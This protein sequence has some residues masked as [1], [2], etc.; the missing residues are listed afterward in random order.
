M[1]QKL[2]Y[3]TLK[4][5]LIYSI[6]ILLVFAP[7]FYFTIEELYIEESDEGLLLRKKEF[8][9]YHQ[10]ALKETE[11]AKWN[12]FNRD[13]K[14]TPFNNTIVADTLYFETIFDTIDNEYEP[15]RILQSPVTIESK[16]YTLKAR[17]NLVE[18]EDLI[19]TISFVFLV[20]MCLLLFGLFIITKLLSNKLWKPFFDSLHFIENFEIDKHSSFEFTPNAIDEFSR[21]NT[22]LKTLIERNSLIYKQ[23]K[24]FIEN[25]AHEMQTPL[26]IF[27]GKLELLSQQNGLT[28]NQSE[29][30]VQLNEAII[31][32]NKLNKNLLLLSRIENNQLGENTSFNVEEIIAKNR[33]FYEEQAI[34]K[35]TK[36]DYTI[37]DKRNV[38][39]NQ[40]LVEILYNNLMTNAL[41]HNINNG[42]ITVILNEQTLQIINTGSTKT[43]EQNKL[44]NRFSKGNQSTQ[45]S[46]LGL[47]IVK[48]I[49][50]A[51]NWNI[52]Y[53]FDNNL[54]SFTVRF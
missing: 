27:Q 13:I 9:T 34:S 53:S 40:V 3:K 35:N 24:E 50:A 17:I 8:V 18:T 49:T 11:I 30:I 21:L 29:I 43:L 15:Y 25:A 48:R 37:N 5:Y 4:H 44:F 52:S 36:I 14:I 16:P 45:G 28:E 46:G 38:N 20:M 19:E 47:A 2:L 32:L 39:S 12:S 42:K 31:R 1:K 6:A 22:A 10:Q 41:K 26:A 23:Q 7:L 51:Y 33:D 54:H